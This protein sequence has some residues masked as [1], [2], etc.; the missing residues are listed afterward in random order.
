VTPRQRV[1]AMLEDKPVRECQEGV[2]FSGTAAWSSLR[3]T[4]P[5]AANQRLLGSPKGEDDH[6][7]S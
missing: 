4:E 2:P 6:Y 3:T 7:L 1:L 5:M